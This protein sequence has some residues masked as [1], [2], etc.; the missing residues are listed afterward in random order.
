MTQS[1]NDDR[2]SNQLHEV[3]LWLLREGWRFAN[4]RKLFEEIAS[5]LVAAGVPLWRMGAYIPTLDPEV[6][7]D[8]FVWRRTDG[9]AEYI[10][11]PYTLLGDENS[12]AARCTKWRARACPS[13]EG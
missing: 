4:Y 12:S 1:S 8:A 6:F 7:G 2:A 9:R 11:A 3:A 10:R 13:V 5:R